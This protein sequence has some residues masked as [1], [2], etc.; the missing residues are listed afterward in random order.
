MPVS[1]SAGTPAG[2]A[3][4]PPAG[5]ATGPAAGT[6][7][8]KPAPPAP[9]GTGHPAPAAGVLLVVGFVLLSLNTRVAFGQIGPLAPV[10]HFGS[11]TVTVLGLLPPLC[12]GLFAPLAPLVRRRLGEERGLLWAGVVL[13]AGAVLRMLGMPGLYAGT[14][15]VSLATAIVNVLV[16]VFV[17]TR[18]SHRHVGTMMGVYALSMGVGSA[19]VAALVAPVAQASGGSWQLAVGIAVVPAVLAVVGIAPQVRVH[20]PGPRPASPADATTAARPHVA[21]TGLAWSLTAFFGIQTLAFYTALAWLPSVLIA[22]GTGRTAAGTCQA[23]LILGVAVGGFLAP[24]L[25]APRA[26]QRPHI[27]GT[28]LVC[29]TGFTG[30]MLAPTGLPA[31]WAAVLG[32]G[33]GAGQALPGVLYARRGTDHDHVAAL[34]TMAQTCGY[35]IAATGPALAAGLH[36]ATGSWTVP[37]AAVTAALLLGGALSSRAGHDPG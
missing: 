15:V 9:T 11:A 14:V 6:T 13:V 25:A 27:L 36:G 2:P 12:M 4:G 8:A 17:R 24:V 21:R 22:S 26:D 16:P 3:V 33:L 7:T 34:S 18:F 37:L 1:S 28:V 10:A 19:I 32:I 29:A 20:R 23:V 30:L 31:L 35:L 5:P